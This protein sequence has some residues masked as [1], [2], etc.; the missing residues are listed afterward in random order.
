MAETK[1]TP[2]AFAMMI[3]AGRVCWF[4]MSAVFLTQVATRPDLLGPASWPLGALWVVGL[5]AIVLPAE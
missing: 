4:L 5:A 2:S 3:A 1:P